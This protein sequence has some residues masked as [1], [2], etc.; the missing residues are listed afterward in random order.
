M[1]AGLTG[2]SRTRVAAIARSP[3]FFC[4]WYWR[5]SV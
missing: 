3:P 2:R 4:R 5:G 1:S